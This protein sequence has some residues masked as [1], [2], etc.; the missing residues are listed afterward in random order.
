MSYKVRG[1]KGGRKIIMEKKK[2]GKKKKKV[3][4]FAET[5]PKK[6]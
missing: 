3:G 5:R 6:V 4:K 2:T 1:V